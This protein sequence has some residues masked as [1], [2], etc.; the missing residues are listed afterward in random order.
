MAKS[1]ESFHLPASPFF[2]VNT[3]SLAI[4]LLENASHQVLTR[5]E[6]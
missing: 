4:E 6:A 1:K 5:E 2:Y 3:W